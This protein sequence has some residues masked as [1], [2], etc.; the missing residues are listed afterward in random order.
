[1][2]K[3]NTVLEGAIYTITE[4]LRAGPEE[5]YKIKITYAE[6]D[7][8][9]FDGYFQKIDDYSSDAKNAIQ[10]GWFKYKKPAGLTLTFT[11]GAISFDLQ[12]DTD[13]YDPLYG[14]L[15]ENEKNLGKFVFNKVGP[16]NQL[17]H[18]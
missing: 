14:T 11:A 10:S 13:T 7:S 15:S 8:G 3:K 9:K 12:T 17:G 16:N 5:F 18:D 1:M 2:V 6:Y 4:K